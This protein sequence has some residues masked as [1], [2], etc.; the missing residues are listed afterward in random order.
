M[1]R[2]TVNLDQLSDRRLSIRCLVGNEQPQ[3][4]SYFCRRNTT[5]WN[6]LIGM[7]L[8]RTFSPMHSE[9]FLVIM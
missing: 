7:I 2:L 6:K 5:D 9:Y 4:R 3:K 1:L 8:A